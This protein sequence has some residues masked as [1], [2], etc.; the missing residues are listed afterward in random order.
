MVCSVLTLC[1]GAPVSDGPVRPATVT[2]RL[3]PGCLSWHVAGLCRLTAGIV[4]FTELHCLPPAG[5]S[6]RS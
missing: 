4:L 5:V 6:G 2:R 3:L 1:F